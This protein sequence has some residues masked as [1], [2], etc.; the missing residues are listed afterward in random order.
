MCLGPETS[1]PNA[2]RKK[3]KSDKTR[4][5]QKRYITALSMLRHVIHSVR[6]ARKKRYI[7]VYSCIDNKNSKPWENRF[8]N[9]NNKTQVQSRL[10]I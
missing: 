5:Q 3:K 4:N 2:R 7:I 10:K 8:G 9:G 1:F 6:S